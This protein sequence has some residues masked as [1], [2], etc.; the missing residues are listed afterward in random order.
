[1]LRINNNE[2][3]ASVLG[4]YGQNGSGKIALVDAIILLQCALSGKSAPPYF[5]D[6]INWFEASKANTIDF[7]IDF[8]EKHIDRWDWSALFN[9]PLIIED[10]DR[11]KSAFKDKLNGIKFIER[12]PDSNP[13]STNCFVKPWEAG[14]EIRPPSKLTRPICINPFKKREALS[15][16]HP[17]KG[18]SR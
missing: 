7:S 9:N 13:K 15:F 4:L 6:Y 11:Y 17:S 3:K 5:A 18:N 12:F 16:S 2:Y 14:S 1:M 8:V 10:A